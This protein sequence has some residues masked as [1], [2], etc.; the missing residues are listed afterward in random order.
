MIQDSIDA[1][2]KQNEALE[3]HKDEY[4]TILSVVDSVYEK[5][6]E[7]IRSQQDAIQDTIDALQ[8][9]NDER[10]F[11][12]QLEQAKWELYRAQTQR[13]KKVYDTSENTMHATDT[14]RLHTPYF[15]KS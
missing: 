4:D 15:R 2:E 12:L 8:E 1:I 7:N 3:K 14:F 13:T 10:K 5:E 6:I 11:A 9:E